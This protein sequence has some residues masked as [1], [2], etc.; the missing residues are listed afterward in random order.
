MAAGLRHSGTSQPF[1][2]AALADVS[3]AVSLAALPVGFFR[4][5]GAFT[6]NTHFPCPF[7][8]AWVGCRVGPDG[9]F[10]DAL[11]P[12]LPGGKDLS[13][14]LFVRAPDPTGPLKRHQCHSP[15]IMFTKQ[16]SR[17]MDGPRS[18]HRCR[19]GGAGRANSRET[20]SRARSEFSVPFT[21][22]PRSVGAREP[23]TPERS[24]CCRMRPVGQPHTTAAAWDGRSCR[25]ER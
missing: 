15:P 9:P 20:W 4:R 21:R 13:H 18:P 8:Q 6:R 19:R 16:V 14:L 11:A 25:S 23:D 7:G 17:P 1:D 12:G 2:S 5:R 10:R 24:A 22:R 3:G